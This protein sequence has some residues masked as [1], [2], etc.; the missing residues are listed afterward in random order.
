MS[1]VRRSELNSRR[2]NR[3][4]EPPPDGFVG[5]RRPCLSSRAFNPECIT[6]ARISSEEVGRPE[7]ASRPFCRLYRD[8]LPL[9]VLLKQTPRYNAV[10]LGR[11][12]AGGIQSDASAELSVSSCFGAKRPHLTFTS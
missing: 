6:S 10:S 8:A 1:N 3:E 11:L 5:V 12:L 7:A 4:T 2:Q 9:G